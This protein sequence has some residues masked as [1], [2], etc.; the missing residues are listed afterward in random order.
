LSN[1]FTGRTDS[2][3]ANNKQLRTDNAELNGEIFYSSGTLLFLLPTD[4]LRALEFEIS[5]L[6]KKNGALKTKL[7]KVLYDD[8]KEERGA[9]I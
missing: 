2:L 6:Q 7:R 4:Q 3:H 9:G 5:E 1:C 8:E